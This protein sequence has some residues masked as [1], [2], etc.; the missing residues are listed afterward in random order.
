MHNRPLNICMVSDFFYPAMGGVESHLYNNSQCLIQ[1]GHKVVIVTHSHGRRRGVRYLA[2]G[3]KVYYI[4]AVIVYS[5]ASLPTFFCTFPIFRQIFIREQIDIVHG[6]QA[7]STFCHEAILHA[8]SMGLKTV[9]TD[10]SLLGFA[11]ASGILLNKLLKFTLSDVQHAICVSHTSKE[12]TVLRAALDPQQVSVIPNA[13]IAEQFRP[14]PS[15]RDPAWITIVVLSRLVYRKGVD[16]LV[17]AMPRICQ[18]CPRVRFIIGGDGPKRINIE[19]MRERHMLQ[20][21]IEL[22][23]SVQPA[24]VRSVLVRGDIFLNTSLTEAFCIAIVEAA[25]CGLLV[26]STKV[27]GIPE[28]LPRYMITFAAPEEDHVVES[29]LEAIGRVDD[30]PK[31]PELSPEYFHSQVKKMYSWQ[32]VAERTEHVY[33]KIVGLEEPPLIER[34]RRYYGCGLVAGKLFCLVA[35]ID[36]LIGVVLAWFWPRAQ[37][38]KARSFDYAKYHAIVTEN[39]LYH[40]SSVGSEKQSS[41]PLTLG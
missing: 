1:R 13:I 14:D 41:E 5:N 26:V 2:G 6:H 23:G 7:F 37:I 34:F 32:D 35:A 22:L 10:H 40:G 21:R 20:D 38:E 28:V 29:L 8:R 16:L 19:Q 27:G 25:A 4:P 36:F 3:L 11:D 30:R 9:F 18:L 15:A 39:R 31:H 33:Y 12:N 24:D 17:A